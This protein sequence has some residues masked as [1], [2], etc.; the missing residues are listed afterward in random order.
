MRAES[1]LKALL[2]NED[3]I[4]TRQTKELSIPTR[5]ISQKREQFLLTTPEPQRRTGLLITNLQTA[6]GNQNFKSLKDM[7][8]ELRKIKNLTLR[9]EERSN[10]SLKGTRLRI[11]YTE[12]ALDRSWDRLKS[13]ISQKLSSGV[14]YKLQFSYKKE[15]NLSEIN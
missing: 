2:G 6:L 10:L 5:E 15:T 7:E 13:N 12:K 1:A 8:D 9:L 14:R 4:T 11:N 3:R